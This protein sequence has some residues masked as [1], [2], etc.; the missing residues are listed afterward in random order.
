MKSVLIIFASV[1]VFLYSSICEGQSKAT[2]KIGAQEWTLRN[3]DVTTFRNGEPIP[4]V[5]TDEEWKRAGDNK[6]PAWCYYDNNP[7]NG[8]IYGKLYNRYAV[9]DA[10]GL[11]PIGWHIPTDAEWTAMI[12][13]LGGEK[14]AGLS[15]KSTSQ[16]KENTS[17]NNKSGFEGYPGGARSSDGRFEYIGK[18][19]EDGLWWSSSE[20]TK[21]NTGRTIHV[22]YEYEDLEFGNNEKSSGY[23]VRCIKDL[24]N[25]PALVSDAK[26]QIKI[27]EKELP[28]VA[29]QS[30]TITSPRKSSIDWVSIP[31]ASFAMRNYLINDEPAEGSDP[32]EYRNRQVTLSA[33]KISKH[34]ITFEQYDAFCDETNRSKP[35]D[36]GWGRGNRPVINVSWQDARDF[37][38]WMGCRLPTEVEW[39]YAA[40][41]LTTTA[42]ITGNN[43]KTTEANYDGNFPYLLNAKGVSR[44][45]T[46]PVG[47]FAANAYGLFDMHGNVSEWCLDDYKDYDYNYESIPRT[48]PVQFESSGTF[49]VVRGGGWGSSATFCR[50]SH[51]DLNQSNA[52]K[53]NIGFR[54]VYSEPLFPFR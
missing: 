4:E 39:E 44:K 51:R 31:A 48:N 38:K 19:G 54:L 42:F 52:R 32:A 29:E 27:S 34:E 23:S 12:E 33:F 41:G 49:K 36:E 45:K 30:V 9:N 2:V 26:S 22:Y 15:M 5:K 7:V 1:Y 46:L 50:S 6:Q 28:K 3:L 40:R 35:S 14:T 47:S 21:G 24:T 43:L 8:P 20:G 17:S 18:L 13:Y 25:Q 11:A 10:R 37:A 16:W 53:N